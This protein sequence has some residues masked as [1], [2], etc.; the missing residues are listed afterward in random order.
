[1]APV[2]FESGSASALTASESCLRCAGVTLS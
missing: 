2:I 1:M